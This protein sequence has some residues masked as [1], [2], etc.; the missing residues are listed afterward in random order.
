MNERKKKES[1]RRRK[2]QNRV[3]IT[4]TMA[5]IPSLK[6]RMC[7]I[8]TMASR[9]VAINSKG[10]L[11]MLIKKSLFRPTLTAKQFIAITAVDFANSRHN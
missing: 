5:K 1:K 9:N 10:G 7:Q 2:T 4:L 6:L 8:T 3:V 11:I